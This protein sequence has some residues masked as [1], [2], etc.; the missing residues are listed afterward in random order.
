ML[1]LPPPALEPAIDA[2]DKLY[3]DLIVGNFVDSYSNLT[4][5]TLSM[6]EWVDTYCPRVPKFLKTDDDMFINI[7]RLLA[8]ASAPNRINATNT[9]WGK[10]LKK[11]L[12]KRTPKSK[13][14]LSPLQYPGKVNLFCSYTHFSVQVRP[15]YNLMT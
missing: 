9:I 13:Y 6:L 8:Y 3:G 11:S 5:K 14:Y 10:V 7:P 4:L 1:G 15:L 2:E 12:P